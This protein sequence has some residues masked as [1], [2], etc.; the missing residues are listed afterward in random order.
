MGQPLGTATPTAAGSCCGP[1]ATATLS[2][3][4]ADPAPRSSQGHDL[5][6]RTPLFVPVITLIAVLTAAACSAP[7]QSGDPAPEAEA[8]ETAAVS[9]APVVDL[10]AS[11]QVVFG[12]FPGPTT[13]EQG[14]LMGQNREL[15]FVFYSLESGPFDIM[16]GCRPRKSRQEIG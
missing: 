12:A 15:D 13:R 4:P 10:I 11:G 3:R 1:G 6:S 8:T 14:T 2:S 7:E 5:M 9:P 16:A